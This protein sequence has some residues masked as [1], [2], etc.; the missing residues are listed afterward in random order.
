MRQWL[1]TPGNFIAVVVEKY[2]QD[3]YIFLKRKSL[4]LE[5]L[6]MRRGST[7]SSIQILPSPANSHFCDC[8]FVLIGNFL[9]KDKE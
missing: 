6:E 3:A 2:S 8:S 5:E 4:Y 9:E 7:P 1:L